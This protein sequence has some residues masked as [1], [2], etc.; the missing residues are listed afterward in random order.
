M[1]PG[2]CD[3]RSNEKKKKYRFLTRFLLKT[4]VI[5][6]IGAVILIWVLR[7]HRMTG[8]SMFPS[9]RDGDLCVFYRLESCTLND[10]VLYK[11]ESGQ[12]KVGRIVAVGG[13]TVDFMEEGGYE[14]DGYQ[15]VDEIPYETYA[16]VRSSV[17]Y[18]VTLDENSYFILNDFR[19]D[20][21][22]SR[23]YGVVDRSQVKGKLLFLLRRRGF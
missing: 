7:I 11:D 2:A 14:I 18:P 22:D 19:S 12:A 6:V 21:A 23:E 1:A 10:V 3:V 9:V 4:C 15:A 13:Q 20:T 16:S 5:I 8:N 17:K